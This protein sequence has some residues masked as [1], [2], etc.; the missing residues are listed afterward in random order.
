[1]N[2]LTYNDMLSAYAPYPAPI[3]PYLLRAETH[4]ALRSMLTK[5]S[6]RIVIDILARAPIAEP[7][8]TLR[9]RVDHIAHDLE[10]SCKTVTRALNLMR[11]QGWLKRSPDSD[12]RNNWGEF[13]AGEFVLG[14]EFRTMLGLP[15]GTTLRPNQSNQEIVATAISYVVEPNS[16]VPA[17]T[18]QPRTNQMEDEG[19]KQTAD[20]NGPPIATLDADQIAQEVITATISP[21]MESNS[22][23]LTD[24]YQQ[25]LSPMGEDVATQQAHQNSP[26]M[27]KMSDGLYTVNKILKKEAS[28]KDASDSQTLAPKAKPTSLPKDLLPLQTELGIHPCGIFKLMG[29][30]KQ[31][32]QRLQNLWIAKRDQILTSGARGGRAFK[33]FE[34]L[35]GCGEDFSYVAHKK[36]LA[37]Q[38]VS[39]APAA[40]TCQPAIDYRLYWNKKFR[41]AKGLVVR[42]HG[43]GS[44]ELTDG[45][46]RDSYI[47]PR[48]MQSVYEA[49]AAGQL[50]LIE[51]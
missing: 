24:A 23:A 11:K 27:T 19:T 51:E 30:A 8:R 40:A 7:L 20:Q 29:L 14:N 1:M 21:A 5:S 26:E 41:G 32:G 9:L 22:D 18:H 48:D 47:T 17:D 36:A 4:P 33:Y 10:L 45:T 31:V 34:F 28:F 49:I 2:T 44:G 25:R 42:V 12:G 43:D 39:L 15:S 3:R 16:E 37:T 46:L 50:W 35:L 13:C 38:S 6:M